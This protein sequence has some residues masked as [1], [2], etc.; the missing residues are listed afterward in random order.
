MKM[1]RILSKQFNI[2]Q[3]SRMA[4]DNFCSLLYVAVCGAESQNVLSF[5][6]YILVLL[7]IK[8]HL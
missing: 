2:N 1:Y 7:C 3:A 6:D 4:D 8:S 5:K